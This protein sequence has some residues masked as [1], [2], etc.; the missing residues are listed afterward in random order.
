MIE[1]KSKQN[2]IYYRKKKY[3]EETKSKKNEKK[4]DVKNTAEKY[5][6][7]QNRGKARKDESSCRGRRTRYM[8]ICRRLF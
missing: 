4:N 1:R 5:K 8:I 3:K 7:E 6:N 2:R